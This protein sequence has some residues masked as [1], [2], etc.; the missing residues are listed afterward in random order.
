VSTPSAPTT[1]LSFTDVLCGYCYLADAR[2]AQ[3][4]AD[5]GGRVRL[6]YHFVSAYGDVRRKIAKGGRSNEAFNAMVREVL[7]R[8]DHV[9]VHRDVFREQV[10]TS[11]VPAHLYLRAVKLL[12]DEGL[13]ESG[14]GISPF[15]RLMGELRRAFFR[16][17]SDIS[18]RD[19]LDDVAERLGIP[20]GLV[21]R[22][23][24]D[25]RAF[26]ELTR[27]A[28]LQRAHNVAVTPSLV[29]N[30]GRQILRGNVGYRVIEASVSELLS[31]RPAPQSWC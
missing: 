8:F 7:G 6:S 25:G 22:A 29:L 21:A 5:F 1:I 17:L 18:R 15:E 24:D 2:L 31:N 4:R 9:E 26:A 30:D 11:S 28:E 19:V 12:E 16:D 20:S 13:L 27:D 14:D 10:P 3:L 23:I